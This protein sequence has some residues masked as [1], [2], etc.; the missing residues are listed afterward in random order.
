[1]HQAQSDEQQRRGKTPRRVGG[2]QPDHSAVIIRHD[3]IVWKH[4]DAAA[5]DR[6]LP[7]DECEARD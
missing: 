4:S 1:L 3:E 5:G 7:I 2:E 6:F